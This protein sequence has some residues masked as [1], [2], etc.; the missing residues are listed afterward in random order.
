MSKFNYINVCICILIVLLSSVVANLIL[1]FREGA[2]GTVGIVDSENNDAEN[3]EAEKLPEAI[4]KRI[5]LKNPDTKSDHIFTVIYEPPEIVSVSTSESSLT[6]NSAPTQDSAVG[7]PTNLYDKK[8]VDSCS[9]KYPDL[10]INNHPNLNLFNK[11]LS[12][13]RL[14]MMT[15]PAI[16]TSLI[17]GCKPQ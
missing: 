16:N 4:Y 5:H 1:N 14:D 15:S 17:Q 2:V 12:D 9:V 10:L 11:N 7:H 6:L 8:K 13:G 3:N